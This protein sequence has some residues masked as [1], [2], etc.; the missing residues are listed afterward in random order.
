M[1][2]PLLLAN[3]AEVVGGGEISLLELA[4]G[5]SARGHEP[6]IAVPGE[7]PLAR[8]FDR[9]VIPSTIGGAAAA[10]SRIARE[11]DLVH[12]T[13]ARPLL[14]AWLAAS[15]RPLLWH[16]RVASRDKLDPLLARMP[17]FIIA[18]S[19]ATA[20]RFSGRTN[21]R[22]VHNGVKATPTARTPLPLDS[23]LRWIAVVARMTPEKGHLDLLQAMETI[24][25]ER[26]DVGFVFIGEDAGPIGDRIRAA[27]DRERRIVVTGR[28]ENAA[29]HLGEFALVVIPSRVEGFG[30][31]AVE[32]MMAGTPLIAR[33]TG[34][35]VE[36]LDE[37]GGPWLPGDPARWAT[38]ILAQLDRPSVLPE[39]AR[40][41][42]DRFGI[43]RHV[44]AI[45]E[46]YLKVLSHSSAR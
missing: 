34:G 20:A 15:G 40:E 32:A 44:A 13:G 42:A 3:F 39:A 1:V 30:R 33:K 12:A 31:V 16:A 25:N 45:T 28:I 17:D 22:I 35:L 24:L 2:R 8:G 4:A 19:R 38:A 46:I 5:L 18:N 7:G 6:I 27:A 26:R 10:I 23:S 9:R 14:S 11:V 29:A 21:V 36:V 43:D 37:T 41:A